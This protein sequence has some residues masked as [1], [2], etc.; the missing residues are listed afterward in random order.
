MR[1]Q[2]FR[3]FFSSYGVLLNR[4]IEES[5][6]HK[7]YTYEYGPRRNRLT[8]SMV[9]EEFEMVLENWQDLNDEYKQ[10]GPA[11]LTEK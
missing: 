2:L 9:F 10:K 6:A 7:I 11:M 1:I 8:H 3:I 5:Y 4:K